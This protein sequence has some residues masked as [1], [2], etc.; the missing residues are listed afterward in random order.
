MSKRK[1][2]IWTG[3]KIGV[4]VRVSKPPKSPSFLPIFRKFAANPCI[5]RNGITALSEQH[6]PLIQKKKKVTIS[7]DLSGAENETRTRDPNLG[8]VVLYQLSYF[9]NMLPGCSRFGIAKVTIFFNSPNFLFGAL[10]PS[11]FPWPD[12]KL[13][14]RT[15]A[16]TLHR[17][18]NRASSPLPAI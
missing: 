8:K 13:R 4:N 12:V 18:Q 9:R 2:P 1:V 16:G 6:N 14:S 11:A 7:D 3:V 17:F 5:V 10:C 15:H